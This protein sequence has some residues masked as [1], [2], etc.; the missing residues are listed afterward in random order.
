MA[1]GW[2]IEVNSDIIRWP[3]M[4]EGKEN[5]DCN[6]EWANYRNGHYHSDIGRASIFAYRTE[7]SVQRVSRSAAI[8]ASKLILKMSTIT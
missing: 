5:K 2:G 1:F 6:G 7:F 4:L 8:L 3:T